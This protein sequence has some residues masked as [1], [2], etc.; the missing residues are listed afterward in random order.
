MT[1]ADAATQACRLS[2]DEGF[3]AEYSIGADDFVQSATMNTVVATDVFKLTILNAKTTAEHVVSEE[4]F[5]TLTAKGV[6]YLTE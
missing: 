6:I 4:T 5:E 1:T 2:K 3:L